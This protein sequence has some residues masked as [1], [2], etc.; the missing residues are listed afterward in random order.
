MSRILFSLFLTLSVILPSSCSRKTNSPLREDAATLSASDPSGE[1]EAYWYNLRNALKGCLA[2]SLMHHYQPFERGLFIPLDER[3]PPAGIRSSGEVWFRLGEMTLAEHSEMLSLAF[4]HNQPR[5]DI[6]KRLAEINLV[7]GQY[8]VAAKYVDI[9]SGSPEYRIWAIRHTPGRLGKATEKWLE[10]KRKD[11]PAN[12]FVHGAYEIRPV[13]LSLLEAN[14]GNSLAREYLLCYDLLVKDLNAFLKDFD[15]EQSSSRL[16]QEAMT[17]IFA[18]RGGAS[19]EE[20][21]HFRVED[22]TLRDFEDYNR[23]YQTGGKRMAAVQES[24]GTTYWFYYQFAT[25]NEK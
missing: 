17:I 22:G 1:V 8:E 11:M 10:S 2:D 19:E 12:D 14:P 24:F 6:L 7:T 9:L 25:R 4:F 23:T 21:A 3:T 18:S 15:P 20:L 16:Y 5:E 13:L